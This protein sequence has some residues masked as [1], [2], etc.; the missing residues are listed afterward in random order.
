M[1]CCSIFVGIDYSIIVGRHAGFG[2][3]VNLIKDIRDF[4]DKWRPS[5]TLKVTLCFL[6]VGDSLN[7][8]IAAV[9]HP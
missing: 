9:L 4:I 3:G 2:Y 8:L 7:K 5:S 6:I 1:K